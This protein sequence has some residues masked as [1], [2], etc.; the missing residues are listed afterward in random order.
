MNWLETINASGN[1]KRKSS[2]EFWPTRVAKKNNTAAA[3]TQ[4]QWLE[5]YCSLNRRHNMR[6]FHSSAIRLFYSNE[7]CSQVYNYLATVC[8]ILWRVTSIACIHCIY[9]CHLAFFTIMHCIIFNVTSARLTDIDRVG[10][11][12]CYHTI[13]DCNSWQFGKC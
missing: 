5:D 12:K 7:Y 13:S 3:L 9:N 11:L 6:L 10:K 4:D 1:G 8:N 2:F